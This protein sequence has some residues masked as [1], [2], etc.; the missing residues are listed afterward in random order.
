M[1]AYDRDARDTLVTPSPSHQ[2]LL[3]TEDGRPGQRSST[4]YFNKEGGAAT[5]EP[6]FQQYSGRRGASYNS[7]NYA[8]A[9]ATEGVRN[10]KKQNFVRRRPFLFCFIIL[11]ILAVIGVAVGVAVSQVMKNNSNNSNLSAES[12]N[13][14]NTGSSSSSSSTSKNGGSSSTKGGNNS[15]SST[16]T[17]AKTITPFPRWNWTDTNTKVYGVSLGS[18]LVLERWQLEDWMVQEGGP[19]AWDEYRFTQALGNRAQSVIQQHQNTWVTEAD[20]DRLENAGINLIRIPIGHWAF[21]PNVGNEAYVTT[22]YVDQLNKMLEW[23]YERNMYVM[24][25]LHGMPGSQNGDQSSGHN[26]TNVQWFE[27]NNQDRSDTFLKAVL[28]WYKGSNYSSIINSIGVVNEPHVV[29]DDFTSLNNTRLRITTDFYE[30]SYQLCVQY[31]I[32]MT[33]HHGFYPGSATQKMDAWRSFVSGKDP[34]FLLYED[35]PYP[36]WFQTPEPGAD[37]IQTSVCEYGTAANGYPIP[38]IIGEFSAIQN[39]NSSAYAKSYLEMQLATY[40][41][42]AGSIFWN[43]KANTSSL[44]VLAEADNLMQLYSYVD[45]LSAGTM[46]TPGKGNNVR[47]FYQSLPNPCGAFQT[48]GW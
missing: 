30:R 47:S 2:G 11:A 4:Y 10:R 5:P 21:I 35:H 39:L 13:K 15:T 27:Q 6:T 7:A 9:G 40:G 14:G 44:Q 45:L 25:D 16:S 29:N 31:G 19:N 18:W 8:A 36:G 26:T 41:W 23:C 48:Y 28:D 42:S 24:L 37:A 3:M 46:P 12:T 33:F 34:N 32:P 43:F 20:M 22:G 38:V 1:D 17:P